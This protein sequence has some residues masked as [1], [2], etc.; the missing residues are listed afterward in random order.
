[1]L[2]EAIEIW[3]YHEY[4]SKKEYVSYLATMFNTSSVKGNGY[5]SFFVATFSF[6]K[7]IQILSL[8]FLLSTTI[9]GDNHVAS[10]TKI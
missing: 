4:P 6:L 1:M 3:W 7:S 5:G 8:P 9:M 10:S 2:S